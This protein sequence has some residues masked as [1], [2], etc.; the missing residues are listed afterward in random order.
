MKECDVLFIV[1]MFQLPS[2]LKDVKVVDHIVPL[3]TYK[4]K[5]AT[6]RAYY[7]NNKDAIQAYRRALIIMPRINRCATSLP[8]SFVYQQSRC[9]TSLPE[10]YKA[11]KKDAKAPTPPNW[12]SKWQSKFQE[13]YSRLQIQ[14]PPHESSTKICRKQ[15]TRN[16]GHA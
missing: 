4:Q 14:I 7:I 12:E 8:K 1:N 3:K 2:F 5:I 15:A 6:R 10:R 13:L 9:A 16:L 11:K